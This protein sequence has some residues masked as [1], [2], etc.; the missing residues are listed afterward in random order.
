MLAEEKARGATLFLN[1]HLLSE[2]ERVCDRIG[3][4]HGGRVLVQGPVEALATRDD[5]WIV[6]LEP[7]VERGGAAAT[8]GLDPIGENR[9]AVSGD[10]QQMNLVLDRARV[11][12][13]IITHLERDTKDLEQLL[14]EAVSKR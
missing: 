8:E 12:G 1:S 14:R 9:F 7:D 5:R 6:R 2:T 3:I 11:A 13:A 4:L 10:A